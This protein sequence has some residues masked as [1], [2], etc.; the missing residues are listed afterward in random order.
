MRNSRRL[1]I[2]LVRNC[3]I[4]LCSGFL[5]QGCI[6]LKT[7][8]D[9]QYHKASYAD[10]QRVSPPYFLSVKVEF[11]RNG[12][13]KPQVDRQ[14]QDDVERTLRASGVAL[15]YD[16]KGSAAGEIH[17]TMNNV[18][19]VGAA[20]A[21]G[22]G[23]GLTFGLVGSHVTDNYEFT[24]RLT[25][26]DQTT[27]RVYRHALMSTVGNASGPPGQSPVALAMA[28]NTV[29]DDAL[30]NFLE[31]TQAAGKLLPASH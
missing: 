14:I 29:V 5:L 4:T 27:E 23:T 24:I 1:T 26:Q 2:K 13:D 15:P 18:T 9:P 25:Q 28:V 17:V 22:F 31:D 12:V 16:G 10:L 19:E 7:Y 11:Q 6:S 21:K 8:V 3:I 20:A 30:L